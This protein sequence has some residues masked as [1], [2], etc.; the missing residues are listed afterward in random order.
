M[1]DQN[2]QEVLK[3]EQ[4][5]RSVYDAAVH[6]TEQIPVQAEQE[7]HVF[8]EKARIEMQDE[9]RDLISKAEAK[10]EAGQILADAEGKSKEL[11][12][13]AKTNFDKAVAYV[14]K[15]ILNRE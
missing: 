13:A 5:A 15:Q 12:A 10:E 6:D 1:S 9:A 14:L 3:L 7:A 4:K 11:D 2:I 8:I